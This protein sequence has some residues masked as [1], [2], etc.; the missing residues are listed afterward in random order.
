MRFLFILVFLSSLSLS[1]QDHPVGIKIGGNLTNLAGDGTEDISS[2]LNFQAGVFTE[3]TLNKDFKIQPELLFSV[4]G[5]K[6]NFEETS[7]RR[8]NYII[9][10]ILVKWL[11]SETF[12]LDAGPQ[13]GLLVSAKSINDSETNIKS[14]FYK[15]DFGIN[16]GVSYVISNKISTSL[17]YYFGLTDITTEKIKNQ[18]RALQLALQYKIN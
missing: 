4:Y 8:L 10:P 5:F 18:N 12:S 3:I 16:A 7:K 15:R 2:T 14:S 6:E 1:A 17:R 11:A 9:L 13:V